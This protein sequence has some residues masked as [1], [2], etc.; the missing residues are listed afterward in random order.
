MYALKINASKD[1]TTMLFLDM[2]V[3]KN[4]HKW[5]PVERWQ[6]GTQGSRCDALENYTGQECENQKS[7]L[8]IKNQTQKPLEKVFSKYLEIP[9]S[10]Y[11]FL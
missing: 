2:Y 8:K 1:I 9:S 7:T 10:N 6:F 3:G 5:K 11:N 4:G